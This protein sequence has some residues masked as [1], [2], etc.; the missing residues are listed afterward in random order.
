MSPDLDAP[1]AAATGG[2]PGPIHLISASAGSGKTHRLVNELEDAITRELVPVRPEAIIATTFT[3]KAAAELRERVRSRLLEKG[4]VE[5][6]QR[7]GAARIGTVNSICAQLVT[8]FA[9]DLGIS[10]ESQ[11]LDEA[12]AEQAFAHALS[13]LVSVSR[14]EDG[15]TVTTSSGAGAALMELTERWPGLDWLKDVQTI[16]AR[17]RENALTPDALRTCAQR[18]ADAL[19]GYL[20]P[21]APDGEA[22]DRALER[23]L[24]GFL[25]APH[26]G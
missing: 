21:T 4:H 18:S 3:V 5:Q 17:A 13:S 20:G 1:R 26:D 8:D 19:L 25:A 12:A 11:G 23:A 6:A 15:Q 16:A 2:E 22:L 7:L 24:D 9:F 10:P 14:E